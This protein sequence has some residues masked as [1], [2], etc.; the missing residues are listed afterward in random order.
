MNEDLARIVR[1]VGQT[2]G[3]D[4]SLYDKA[5]LAISIERRMAATGIT[6]AAA[7]GKYL[8]ENST[9]AGLFSRGLNITYSEFFRNS[10]TF[11]LLEQLLL[12][13]LIAEK[14]KAGRAEIRVWSAACAAGQEAYSIAILLDELAAARGNAVS[15]RIFATDGSDTEIVAAQEG[16][17][18]YAAVQSVRWKHIR[19]YFIQEGESYT[20]TPALRDRIDFSVYD[21]LDEFSVSPPPS[22]YG[23]FDLVFCGNLL[24]YYRPDIRQRILNKMWNSLS[25]TG[26]LITGEVERD[27]VAGNE[28]FRAAI[29]PSAVFQKTKRRR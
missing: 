17:Y 13:G 16:V 8:S 12:P 6:T 9:E 10:L 5:F 25:P 28:G 20:I 7:Y 11:A 14:E 22:I 19:D 15:F 23:D 29:P 27:I 21:L 1:V 24:F 3:R 2:H 26:Y 18:D 4:I